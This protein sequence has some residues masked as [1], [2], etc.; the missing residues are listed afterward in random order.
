MAAP[1]PSRA[2]LGSGPTLVVMACVLAGVGSSL[3][4]G[5][6]VTGGDGS[7]SP[8]ADAP[9]DGGTA[10][11]L[12]LPELQGPGLDGDVVAPEDV[13]VRTAA[14]GPADTATVAGDLSIPAR[15]L[16]AYQRAAVTTAR[17][18]PSCGLRWSLLA[19]I[20]RIESGHARG[21]AVT[22]AGRTTSPI[23]GPALSGGPGLA[24][25][26][27]TDDGRHDGDTVWDRAV[28]PMQFIPSSWTLYGTDGN[29]DG[30]ADPHNVDDAALAA[31]GYLCA[32][33]RDL[34]D[35]STLRRAVY[36]YNHS[37]AY[38]ATV[39]AWMKAYDEGRTLSGDGA[40]TAA[41]GSDAR[42]APVVRAAPRREP[43]S[44]DDRQARP[45]PT[46]TSRPAPTR[47]PS[48]TPTPSGTA[49][50]V[51]T[52][53][54]TSVPTDEPTTT[55]DPTPTETPTG[56]PTTTPTPDPTPTPTDTFPT[57]SPTPT[58]TDGTAAAPTPTPT[59]TDTGSPT[60]TGTPDP[61]ATDD[62][63]GEPQPSAGPTGQPTP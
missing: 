15:V 32:G 5:P 59:P 48:P 8:A 50:S 41:S 58:T 43:R 4:G 44:S 33:D 45:R 46:K 30:L 25:I 56:G 52:D 57:P 38:V 34:T 23:L 12:T 16:A 11:D 29:R 55:P 14:A 42:T 2:R 19:S 26:R 40:V 1:S 49:T 47:S 3:T 21:G 60:P 61:C 6:S 62:A 36:G 63:S 54:P 51:P 22:A 18:D 35:T 39:L 31:A 53:T 13:Q 28:G 20:G 37:W 7:R 10:K 24:T 27:D 17:T 9:V